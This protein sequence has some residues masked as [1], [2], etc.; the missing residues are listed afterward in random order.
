M[1]LGILGTLLNAESREGSARAFRWLHHGLLMLGL[2]AV[3]ELTLQ[4]TP[5]DRRLLVDLALLVTAFFAAEWLLRLLAAPLLATPPGRPAARR[6]YLFSFLGLVDL[7]SGWSIPLALLAGLPASEAATLGVLWMLKLTRYVAGFALIGRVLHNER[8]ALLSVLAAFAMVLLLAGTAE[9][10]LER[11]GQPQTFG[12]LPAALWWCIV[13]LTTTGYGD[14]IP[15]TQLGH[16]VASLVMILGIAIFALWAGILASGFAAE[17]RRRD[18]LRTWAL[19]AKVPLF[20]Q[21]GAQVIAEVARL[22]RPRR[23]AAGAPLMRK[24]EP[25]DCMYFIVDGEVEVAVEPQPVR[26]GEGA[27]LGEMA[28]ITGEPRSASVLARRPTQLLALDIADFRAL[29]GQHPELT[30]AI[31]AE[32]ARRRTKAEA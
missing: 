2:I 5:I 23:I 19:V 21:L 17:I 11:G 3:I 9:Y 18:F 4:S 1:G 7:V 29:A 13:T 32:A 30:S 27:F 22:L 8:G 16:V 25:G 10:L 12:S 6:H 26:L 24:G 28:L 15:A 20:R 14:A 31:E